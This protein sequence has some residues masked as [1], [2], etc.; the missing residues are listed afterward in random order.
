MSSDASKD[1][2]GNLKFVQL[3]E[4]ILLVIIKYNLLAYNLFLAY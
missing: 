2:K 4:H 3:M 1:S